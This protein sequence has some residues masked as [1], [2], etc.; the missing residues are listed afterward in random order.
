M[1]SSQSEMAERK[2]LLG[3]TTTATYHSRAI[4]DL[5]LESQ[6]RHSDKATVTGSTRVPQYP[7]QPGGSPWA[8]DIVPSEPPLGYDINAQ[9][10]TGNPSEASSAFASLGA[11][12]AEDAT[13][14]SHSP[15]AHDIIADQPRVGD[16]EAP[17]GGFPPLSLPDG[18][19]SSLRRGRKL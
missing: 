15:Q 2:A 16:D 4:A 6:G 11:D 3:S 19:T 5:G 9:E 13:A 10:I 7:R 17:S 18:A 14:V 1:K 8:A 12:D